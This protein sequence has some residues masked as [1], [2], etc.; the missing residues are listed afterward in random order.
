MDFRYQDLLDEEGDG[1]RILNAYE[2]LLLDALN[3]DA[4]LFAR[5]DAVQSCW[6]FVEPI[7]KYQ[8]GDHALHGY[9]SGTWGPKEAESLL[10][11]DGR[12]WRFP[13]KNLA[14]THYCEL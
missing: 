3:G 10:R 7:L 11:R 12:T 1:V 2:R 9:A 8:A 6:Q 14:N 5:S 4:T 13:C